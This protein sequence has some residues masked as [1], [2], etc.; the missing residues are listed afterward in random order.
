MGRA[1][2]G[3]ESTPEVSPSTL[4]EGLN[5]AGKAGRPQGC[6]VVPTGPTS[7]RPAGVCDP[8]IRCACACPLPSLC[9]LSSPASTWLLTAARWGCRPGSNHRCFALLLVP[10]WWP[11]S[12]LFRKRKKS[13]GHASDLSRGGDGCP[14]WQE[15]WSQVLALGLIPSLREI[16]GS[17]SFQSFYII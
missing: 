13:W 7:H 11:V 8:H 6:Q 9:P 17:G 15:R 14:L 4:R 1:F 16:R 5:P 2:G 3:K 12:L 10:V